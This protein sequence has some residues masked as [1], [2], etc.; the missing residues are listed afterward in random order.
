MEES[1][2][3]VSAGAMFSESLFYDMFVLY[4]LNSERTALCRVAQG[5]RVS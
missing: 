4:D 1:S 2:P 3:G 5:C